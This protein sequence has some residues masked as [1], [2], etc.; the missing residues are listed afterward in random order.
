MTVT[1]GRGRS[2]SV[3]FIDRRSPSQGWT[4]TRMAVRMRKLDTARLRCALGLLGALALFVCPAW[5]PVATA[6]TEVIYDCPMAPG[7]STDSGPW[8]PFGGQQGAKGSC[9]GG[10][11]DF[12][13][14]EGAS[15]SPGQVDGVQVVTPAG[16][17]IRHA[18]V[19]W[20]VPHQVSG[21]DTFAIIS[22]NTGIVG[23]SATPTSQVLV[24]DFDLPSNTSELTLASYCADDDAGAGCSMGPGLAPNL[25]LYGAE[26]TLTDGAL[27]AGSATGG[28]LLGTGALSGVQS[29]S[30]N[31][32][33]SSSGVR[34]VQLRVDGN[35][36]AQKDYI[37]SCPYSN[38]LA[39]P[40]GVSDTLSFNTASVADGE[41]SLELLVQ[42][43]AQNTSVVYSHVIDTQNAT[44]LSPLGALPG[45]GSAGSGST[46]SALGASNGANASASAE[47]RLGIPRTV[48][49]D[50]A[51][52]G[53][54]VAGRLLDSQGSPIGGATLDVVQQISG[55]EQGQ[56]IA[57][58][59][60]SPDGTFSADVAPGPSRTIEV[61]YRAFAGETGYAAQAKVLETVRARVRFK[62]TPQRTGPDGFITLAGTVSGPIPAHGVAVDLWVHY[63]GEWVPFK[64]PRTDRSG[65]FHVSYQF[66]GSVGHFPFFAE[67]LAGQPGFPYA[68]AKSQIVDVSTG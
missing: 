58:P 42:S 46:P 60:T 47:L 14:P 41:H 25:E 22:A 45:P 15:M 31:A 37:A 39:C 27:P 6:G 61:A 67:V 8:E 18:K 7:E 36:V 17:T 5:T 49:R 32:Q 9:S 33:E 1:K 64:R 29:I 20:F 53:L 4:Q 24:S 13:G 66:Q 11:G 48:K 63:R 55:A 40:P 51:H 12:I 43:A 59:R 44:K 2:V 38:F 21:A 10:V 62:V 56:V 34:L 23:E 68:L 30:Y 50:F 16:I 57:H 54:H 28:G 52:R 3:A 26:L 65:H 19:W 35:V